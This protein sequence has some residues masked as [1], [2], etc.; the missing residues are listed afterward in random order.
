MA[1]SVCAPTPDAARHSIKHVTVATLTGRTMAFTDRRGP[2]EEK[3]TDGELA[4]P[5][6]RSRPDARELSADPIR[7][8]NF[9]RPSPR[10]HDGTTFTDTS[11]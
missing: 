6:I 10:T 3:S 1:G 11:S 5:C 2:N 8:A 9:H 4:I 7:T